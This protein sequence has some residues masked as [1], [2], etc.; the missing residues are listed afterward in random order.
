M[1]LALLLLSILPQRAV[2]EER[3]DLIE[4]NHLYD[5][6]A[7]AVLDQVIFYD[8]CDR[9]WIPG[10]EATDLHPGKPGYLSGHYQIVFWR[11]VKSDNILP[12]REWP[13]GE[14]HCL[15]L[16]GD[17]MRRVTSVTVFSTSSIGPNSP[18][19][20]SSRIMSKPEIP[21]FS[22]DA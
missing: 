20:A 1:T 9:V 14:Y 4:V 11:L 12:R 7:K 18:L 16:D 3:V 15:W 2:V 19:R 5:D 17:V 22:R 10:I 13:S 21:V 6:N 8:W